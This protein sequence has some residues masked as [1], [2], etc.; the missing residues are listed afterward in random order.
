VLVACD[1]SGGIVLIVQVPGSIGFD[2]HA[3]GI[4]H[5]VL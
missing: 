1:N 3:I 2:E 4:V 5:E